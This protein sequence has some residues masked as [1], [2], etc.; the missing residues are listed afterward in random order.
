MKT[1]VTT[2]ATEYFTSAIDVFDVEN[3]LNNT[4]LPVTY[5][6]VYVTLVVLHEERWK[7][8]VYEINGSLYVTL[9]L[10]PS[11]LFGNDVSILAKDKLRSFLQTAEIEKREP[12]WA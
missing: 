11:E 8:E 12:A 7:Q 2:I 1:Q 5:E 9:I 6:K 10:K 4:I 3:M